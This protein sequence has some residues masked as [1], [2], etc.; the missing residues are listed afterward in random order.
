MGENL[1]DQLRAAV[2]FGRRSSDALYELSDWA[3]LNDFI[4]KARR[5]CG[6]LFGGSVPDRK[7]ISAGFLYGV[8]ADLTDVGNADVGRRAAMCGSRAQEL[9]TQALLLL[10]GEDRLRL[11]NANIALDR[12]QKEFHLMLNGTIAVANVAVA[13][14]TIVEDVRLFFPT[15]LEDVFGKVDLFA[16][17]NGRLSLCM[18]VK[19]H[20]ETK[21]CRYEILDTELNGEKI[22]ALPEEQAIFLQAVRWLEQTWEARPHR[23]WIAAY[24]HVGIENINLL[25]FEHAKL[26]RCLA[27]FLENIRK[28]PL[29][30][31]G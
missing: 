24:L 19:A 1:P 6:A 21:R 22:G 3:G 20:A 15:P 12:G 11:R 8:S 13:L 26:A 17:M 4:R 7:I 25:T 29:R 16:R 18:Q 14:R 5:R 2:E 10:P 23:R 31:A 9:L 28:E 30:A 27:S